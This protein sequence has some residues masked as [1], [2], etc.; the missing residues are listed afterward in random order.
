M[1]H[2][3]LSGHPASAHQ[4]AVFEAM[5]DPASGSKTIVAVAGAGKTTVIK[6]GLRY[7]PTNAHVQ[8]LAF[9][10]AAARNLKE[11]LAEV[12]EKDGEE[13]YR[14]VRMGTFHSVCLRGLAR[15]LK[16]SE[17]K[18]DPRKLS[19]LLKKRL[20]EI[21]LEVYGGFVVKLVGFAKGEGIGALVPD[22]EERWWALVEH[23]GLYLETEDADEARGVEIAR[24]LLAYSNAVA[25]RDADIDFDDMLYLTLLW[26]LRL[27]ANDVVVVDEVQDSNPVMRAI[28]R[29]LLKPTGRLFAVGDPRQS[30]FGFTGASIDAMDRITRDFQTQE[31]PLTVS[32]RCARSVVERARTWVDHIEPSEFAP[33]GKVSDNVQLSEALAVL[34]PSD[35]ILCRQTAPLVDLAYKLIGTGRGCRVLGREI[36]EGL[37]GLIG[38]MRAKGIEDLIVRLEAFRDREMAKF[39]AKGEDERAEGVADR[40]ACVLTVVNSLPEGKNRTVPAVERRLVDLF[41]VD[42]TDAEIARMPPVL[43][44]STVH[45]SKGQEYDNVAVLAP[46]LMPSKA[47]RQEH[48]IAQEM[49]LMYVA[50]TRAKTV[51]MYLAE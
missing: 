46:S 41:Q 27:W 48:Q 38:K 6:N 45:K 21:E 14:N 30:I 39:I 47:A 51:L 22:T 20:S 1:E 8:G 15:H 50:A 13:R 26:K 5:A 16:K 9:G 17:L 3:L 25:K 32:Y 12:V 11:A 7:L 28:T 19:R 37:I 18:A 36:G 43:T 4:V 33:E 2:V 34:G 23:H 29:L 35:A 44:L 31:L 40:V 24:K 42:K 49:N 10:N